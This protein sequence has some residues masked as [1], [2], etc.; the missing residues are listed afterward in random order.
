MYTLPVPRA[1]P[2]H[3]IGLSVRVS[4][5]VGVCPLSQDRRLLRRTRPQETWCLSECSPPRTT[6]TRRHTRRTVHSQCKRFINAIM[7]FIPKHMDNT[8]A[9]GR[10]GVSHHS[11]LREIAAAA[12]HWIS[13]RS[14][15]SSARGM[16]RPPLRRDA[17]FILGGDSEHTIDYTAGCMHLLAGCAFALER[18]CLS[19]S[20]PSSCPPSRREME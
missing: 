8:H 2:R 9:L 15:A 19:T 18:Q 7:R 1:R 17:G 20:A 13:S 14:S 10:R 11:Y 16:H 12:P 3:S 5:S 6:R 4:P